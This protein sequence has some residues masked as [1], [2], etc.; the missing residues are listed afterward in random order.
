MKFTV[1]KTDWKRVRANAIAFFQLEGRPHVQSTLKRF[2]RTSAASAA[3]SLIAA[4]DMTGKKEEMFTLYPNKKDTAAKRILLAGLGKSDKLSLEMVRRAAARA[5]KKAEQTKSRSLAIYLPQVKGSSGA[6]VAYAMVE[7]IKLGLYKFDKFFKKEEEKVLLENII[8]LEDGDSLHGSSTEEV[9]AAIAE[10]ETIC[11]A[12]IF[13]REMEN[14][15]S[16]NK[17]PEVLA[18]WARQVG[19]E[20][21]VT[22]TIFGPKELA[23]H[24]MIGTISVNQGSVKEPR[25]IIMEYKGAA[26]S[27]AQ[28]VVLVGK[29]I[30][31]DTGGISI[32]PAAGMGD[33]KSDMSGAA[34]VIATIKA[35][36]ELK[37]PV[38]VVGLAASAENMPSGSAMRPGDVITYA[39]GL[40]VEID[41]TDAEGRLV[42]ADALIWADRYK[43]KSV[44]DLA[45]LT[46]ACVVALGHVTTGMMGTDTTMMAALKQAGETTYERVCELPIYDEYDELIKSDVADIKNV[47]GRWAGAITAAMFLK[48]FT[49]YPWVHLDIAGT[50]RSESA[51]DYIPKGG[52]GVAVRL[53]TQMLKQL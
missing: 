4:G 23:K 25:F 22:V 52:T 51:A 41:N 43:P 44:I 5:A 18:N 31:F 14:E 35:A 47:G 42:L 32:K 10:A 13:A 9:K 34:T 38:N 3:E 17:Y 37:L 33:M 6:E 27:N 19:Q 53:L 48:R 7:G 40:S 46:G 50:A 16:N 24:N 28:P 11:D 45:T 49:T 29:G 8:I 15:P 20:S 21:G 12:T 39:N 30:T 1:Q 36:A 26:D 2:G